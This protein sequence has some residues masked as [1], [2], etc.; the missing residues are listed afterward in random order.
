MCKL[1]QEHGT[2]VQ[3]WLERYTYSRTGQNLLILYFVSAWHGL[4]PGF[5]IFFLSIPILTEIER[6]CKTKLNKLVVPSTS[7]TLRRIQRVWFPLSLVFCWLCKSVAMNY[8]TMTMSMGYLDNSLLHS[9]ATI[10]PHITF[11][12]VLVALIL[13]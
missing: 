10:V 7:K 5:F 1:Y 9:I 6:I 2:R 3:A 12:V 13:L 8:V 4:Y 11:V